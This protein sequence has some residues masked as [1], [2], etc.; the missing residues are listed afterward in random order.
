MRAFH[1]R[2]IRPS[3]ATLIAVGD[4]DHAEIVRLAADAFADWT[5]TGDEERGRDGGPLPQPARSE[6]RAA[7][8]RAAVGAAHRP[9]GGRRATR[10]TTIR[11]SSANTILG[12]QFVSRINLNLRED[13]GLTYGARTAFEFRRLLGPVRRCR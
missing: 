11:W 12:G 8:R 7:A 5:G 10:P 2:A 1:A 4:C 13:K 9:G 6:H 3:V